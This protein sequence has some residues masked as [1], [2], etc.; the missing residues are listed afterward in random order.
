MDAK[1]T[2]T[3]LLGNQTTTPFLVNTTTAS[4]SSSNSQATT[5]RDAIFILNG[6]LALVGIIGNVFVCVIIVRGKK[7]YTIANLFLINLAIADLC[8]LAISYPLWLLETLHPSWPFGAALCKIIKSVSDAFYGVSLGCMTTIS[9]HRYRMIL[10]AMAAQLTFRQSK[11]IIACIWLISLLTISLPLYPV[12]QHS[13]TNSGQALCHSVWPTKTYEQTYQSF[14]L[15]FWYVCPLLIIFFTFMKI[16]WFLKKEMAYEWLSGS[17]NTQLVREHIAGIKKALHMLAPVVIVFAILLFPWNL[18]RLLNMFI[19][20]RTIEN[21][22]TYTYV[23]GTMLIANSVTNPFIYYIMSEEFRIEFK[24]QLWFLKVKLNIKDESIVRDKD[25]K[26]ERTAT[27]Y[28]DCTG[29]PV[30]LQDTN[31]KCLNNY[32]VFDEI[33]RMHATNT[34]GNGESCE[35][36]PGCMPKVNNNAIPSDLCDAADEKQTVSPSYP[37]DITQKDTTQAELNE[38]NAL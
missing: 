21:M 38:T 15:I 6:M 31:G 10:H 33:F 35:T 17:T 29:T 1:T 16:K 26:K 25:E 28:S 34:S 27:Q 23:A 12:I 8:V 11:L 18:L 19:D 9:I 24:K 36:L 2:T 37:D 4:P 5:T 22:E 20:I 13:K 7:M 32:E 30:G 14:L 3:L